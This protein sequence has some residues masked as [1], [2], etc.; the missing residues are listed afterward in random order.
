MFIIDEIPGGKMRCWNGCI[1]PCPQNVTLISLQEAEVLYRQ[2]KIDLAIC[3]N[4]SDLMAIRNWQ[5]KKVLCI[6]STVGGRILTEGS[7]I[8]HKEWVQMVKSYLSVVKDVYLVS[9][10]FKKAKD[11]DLE[12]AIIEL[13]V[14]PGDYY[15]YTGTLPMVL[16]VSNG[17]KQRGKILGFDIHCAILGEHRCE[18]VGFNRE[19]P[20][21]KPTNN[22]DE[23]KEKYRENRV[24]LYTALEEYEDGYNTAMLEAMVTG[25]PV[26]SYK[27]NSSPIMDGVNGY[28]SDSISYLRECLGHLLENKEEAFSL[29]QEARKTALQKFGLDQFIEKWERLITKI[30]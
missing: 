28:I 5:L 1:R 7:E 25:M 13:G 24:Y 3:H 8:N 9:V 14:D 15:G 6:H 30:I 20:D 21:S 18:I 23:L 17:F 11:W 22:W 12:T 2:N 16:T 10:S 27:N 26:I 4:L 29:G 19:L